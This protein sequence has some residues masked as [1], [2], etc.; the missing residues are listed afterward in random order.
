MASSMTERPIGFRPWEISAM[1]NVEVVTQHAEDA[2]FLWLSRDRAVRAPHYYLKDLVRLDERVEA[3]VD[4]LRVAGPAGWELAAKALA[5]ELPGEIFVAAVLAFESNISARIDS[6]LKASL[7][8]A[9]LLRPVI[10]ALGWM[11]FEDAKPVLEQLI[12]AEKSELRTIAIGGYAAHRVDPG[13]PLRRVVSDLSPAVQSRAFKTAGELGRT[14][15]AHTIVRYIS[16][17]DESCRFYAAWAAARLGLRDRDVLDALRAIAESG[18]RY[19]ELAMQMALR[20]MRLDEART[21]LSTML[22]NPKSLRLGV[23]GIGAMGDPVL[24]SELI[25]YMQ[26]EPVSRVAGEA[27]A[28]T[29]GVDLKYSDLN[30]P[31]PESFEAG[32]NDDPADPN[33]AMDADEDLPW[34]SLDLVRKWWDKHEHEYQSGVRHLRGKPIETISLIDTLLRGYQRQ[35][36][37]AALEL[38]LLQPSQPIFEVCAPGRRQDERLATWTS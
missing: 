2:A 27:F 3:N 36:A 34:P 17:K 1:V 9:A 20:C 7:A 6:V 28:M 14:D 26:L 24:V 29:T 38:A 21:W 12:N 19:S 33:V 31:K 10:S 11:R 15:L 30:R 32:P 5:Q 8:D 25:G 35:R 13:E 4:G 18:T 37:A 22:K 23:I 16:E